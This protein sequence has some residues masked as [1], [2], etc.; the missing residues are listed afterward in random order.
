[1]KILLYIYKIIL[2]IQIGV[3]VLLLIHWSTVIHIIPNHGRYY[4]NIRDFRIKKNKTLFV[5]LTGE[6]NFAAIHFYVYVDTF[7]LMNTELEL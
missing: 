2:F 4:F 3:K 1:M 5:S 6:R 7:T